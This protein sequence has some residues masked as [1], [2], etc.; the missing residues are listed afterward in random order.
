MPKHIARLILLMVV[1]GAVAYAAKV[2]FTADSFYAYGHYRGNSVVEIASDKPKYKGSRFCESCHA[3]QYALWSKGVH[4]SAD[5]G[6][7]VQCEVCHGAA[8]G[9]DAGGMFQHVAT[10]VDHPASGK[11]AIPTDTLKLCPLCHEKMPGRPAEQ[12]QIVIAAH[13][14]TQQCTTCHNPHSPK[15]FVAAAAPAPQPGNAAAGKAASC[16]GCHGGNGVSTNPAWP[17]LAGQQSAY[18]VEALKAYKTGARE[19]AMMAATA[20]GLTDADMQDL[21]SYYATLKIKAA[22][23]AASGQDQAAGKARAAACVACHGANGV[24]RNPAWPSLAGQQKDY[25]VAALK[26]Y[27]EGT[28]KNEVMA[29]IAKGLSGADMEALAAYYSST[30]L[31]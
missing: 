16:A 29:G 15:L 25:M 1:F 18:L 5:L 23:T 12:R 24:S 22:T 11:L 7:V 31:N 28:R 9:R 21:A 13:A 8:G 27:K 26:A 2:F 4:H 17:S 20:K 19:N 14:G 30:S 6:K 3:E 10:G